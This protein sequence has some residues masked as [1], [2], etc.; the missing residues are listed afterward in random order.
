MKPKHK[1]NVRAPANK[2]PTVVDELSGKPLQVHV[3]GKIEST[4]HPALVKKYDAG[5]GKQ[6]SR[7]RLKLRVEIATLLAL[8]IYTTVTFWQAC[9]THDVDKTSQRQLELDQRPWVGLMGTNH[10]SSD[11]VKGSPI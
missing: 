4:I 3:D 9:T 11:I 7:E 6:E 2:D 10:I 1:Q 5:Q 8:L